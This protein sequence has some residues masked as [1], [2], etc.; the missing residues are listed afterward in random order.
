MAS[1][2]GLSMEAPI[3]WRLRAATSQPS[4][5]ASAQSSEAAPNAARPRR[6]IRRRPKRSASAPEVISRA[7]S[8]TV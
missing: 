2:T 4:D 7:V 1:A 8:T 6:K 5:G 3:P